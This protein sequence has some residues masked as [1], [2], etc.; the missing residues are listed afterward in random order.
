M[1]FYEGTEWEMPKVISRPKCPECGM[2]MLEAGKPAEGRQ[3]YECLRCGH[4]EVQTPR[5]PGSS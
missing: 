4:T 1:T 2:R 5:Q 3:T